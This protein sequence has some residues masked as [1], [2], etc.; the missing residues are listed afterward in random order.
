MNNQLDDKI[1]IQCKYISPSDSKEYNGK[2]SYRN[3]TLINFES[4]NYELSLSEKSN[5][6]CSSNEEGYLLLWNNIYFN[7]G[8]LVT[9]GFD[10]L[11]KGL[12]NVID[13]NNLK[14]KKIRFSFPYINDFFIGVDRIEYFNPDNPNDIFLKYIKTNKKFIYKISD[15][16]NIRLIHG[17]ICGGGTFSGENSKMSLTKEIEIISK[18]ETVLDDFLEITRNLISFFSLGLKRKLPIINMYSLSTDNSSKAKLEIHP[19]QY[20]I[21][22][23]DFDAKLMRNETLFVF[24][25]I[26]KDFGKVIQQF[27]ALRQKDYREFSVIVDLYLRNHD[28]PDEIY[29]QI[30][31]L[32][33]AQAL[34]A[35]LNSKQYNHQKNANS[36]FS[37]A[38]Q[39]LKAQY[40]NNTEIQKIECVNFPSFK[41]K[42]LNS[43]IKN[44]LIS[45]VQFRFK[46]KNKIILLDDLINLRNYF[47]HYNMSSNDKRISSI[48]LYELTICIKVLL[49]LFILCDLNFSKAALKTIISN[50]YYQFRK[51]DNKYIWV[52]TSSETMRAPNTQYLG[53][54]NAHKNKNGKI[55]YSICYYYKELNKNEVELIVKY[56]EEGQYTR[57]NSHKLKIFTEELA[58]KKDIKDKDIQAL[59]YIFKK[60]YER[61]KKYSIQQVYIN[62][63]IQTQK[64]L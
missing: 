21:L 20:K 33:F 35:Y 43:I 18:K 52:D 16:F 17:V 10:C 34:E 7:N 29:P 13:A 55:M 32:I 63:F 26:K 44:D 8:L 23:K 49:E 11:I 28:A 22:N 56:T 39:N 51:F 54:D 53:E 14:F 19:F 41:E 4:K 47:T 25:H 45:L 12:K 31:F 60:C 36:E 62:N 58:I 61:Y 30:K 50:N 24:P 46:K 15:N 37:N 5:L 27:I 9:A 40:P 64:A 38:I 42:I 59:D 1:E 6:I 57:K 2:I 3:G 48:D